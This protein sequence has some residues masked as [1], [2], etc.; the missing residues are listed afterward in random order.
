MG[1]I[2]ENN[3]LSGILA[4]LILGSPLIL[5]YVWLTFKMWL[6]KGTKGETAN[7]YI[8]Y[9]AGVKSCIIEHHPKS[10]LRKRPPNASF[11]GRVDGKEI[12]I[13]GPYEEE[14]L[15][16]VEAARWKLKQKY[17]KLKR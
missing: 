15:N 12:S 10:N 3:N 1:N 17:E 16:G 9:Q 2:M 4:L 8:S 11:F 13:E 7:E 6:E 14:F 5:L